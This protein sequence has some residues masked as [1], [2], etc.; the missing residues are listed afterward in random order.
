MLTAIREGSK[1]W[2]AS[3]VIGLIVLTFA[4]WGIGSYFEGG[5]QLPVATV[6]GDEID[7][8]TYQNQ[9]SL[10]RQS[11]AS[12]FGSSLSSEMMESLGLR[13]RVLDNLI[14]SR[15]VSQYTDAQN[16]RLT[17][18]QVADR[19]RTNQAFQ[20][21]GNFDPALYERI[22][23]S[24]GLSPQA[25]ESSERQTGMNL[26][27]LDAVA[28]TSF[29]VEPEVSHL[30]A[31]QNQSRE[32]QYAVIPGDRYQDEFEIAEGE[33]RAEY[34]ENIEKYQKPARIRVQY[35]DLS[36]SAIAAD[37][38]LPEEEIEQTY[39]RI[40]DRLKSPEV[41]K[42]SH[43]LISVDG[44]SEE[45][46]AEALSK[47]ESVLA[48]AQAGGN[49]AEL[50]KT[51]SDDPGSAGRGG[52]LGVIRRGQMVPPFEDA[53]FSMAE[54][55]VRGVVE[56]RFG[57]HIIQLT[58]LQAEHQQSLDDAREEV[59][60]EARTVA[61]EAIFSDLVEPFDNAIFEEPE[62]LAAAADV[63][64]FPVRTSAWFTREQGTGIAEESVVRAAAF[65]PDV[66]EEGLN[67]P[68]IEIGF[69]RIVALRKL[70]Y[71]EAAPKT[72]EEVREEITAALK[73]EKSQAK[74]VEIANK[75]LTGLTH[76]ASWDI[77]LATQEW[78]AETLPDTRDQVPL[79]LSALAESV[80][81][82][83][84]PTDG[85]PVYGHAILAN[86]DVAMYALTGVTPGH[87]ETADSTVISR[88]EQ[89]LLLRDGE[90]AF[91]RLV[92]TLRAQADIVIHEE[93]VNQ[94]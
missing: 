17:D 68:A 15:L 73:L 46:K 66:L 19:I 36:V 53:V 49:F 10:E 58:E 30:I 94:F 51:H 54:G 59:V 7:A 81:T 9:L 71:E 13:Q 65:R 11:L 82:A 80:F 91:R 61:A 33:L 40:R 26:Q 23:A 63:T 47:A 35:I 52:D 42:A 3:I 92:Q 20:T 57:Y 56:T 34:E 41:R 24:N 4:L 6:N 90:E 89:A 28:D 31:L 21:D 14:E 77:M 2:L 76:I 27:L 1:G 25:F 69:D 75:L 79:Y 74:A 48:Q 18:Q 72:F 67:S 70:D 22:L 8:Y 37:I 44:D 85:I 86:G 45:A 32:T 38:D 60:A 55:E 39:E 93:Q 50:A 78:R 29:L 87:R 43:I 12:Q 84:V 16:Y 5:T 88:L 83:A 62:S 64:G